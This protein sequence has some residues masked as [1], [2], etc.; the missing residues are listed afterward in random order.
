MLALI[1]GKCKSGEFVKYFLAAICGAV[2]VLMLTDVKLCKVMMFNDGYGG[3]CACEL[4]SFT[5][6]YICRVIVE[7]DK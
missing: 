4:N 3:Q 1:F 7:K 5:D 2:M 6:I